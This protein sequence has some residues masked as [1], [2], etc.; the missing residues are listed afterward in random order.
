MEG[1]D[2]EVRS[3]SVIGNLEATKTLAWAVKKVMESDKIES[4]T[5]FLGNIHGG[6]ILFRGSV[7]PVSK[8]S[9][10]SKIFGER[11]TAAWFGLTYKLELKNL[12][13]NDTVSFTLLVTQTS[14]DFSIARNRTFATISIT[15]V[16]GIYVF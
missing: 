7:N 1:Q 12:Q 2:L 14:E 15:E 11:I 9:S 4:A 13:Y 16:K 3:H 10:A 8:L 6:E 5:L